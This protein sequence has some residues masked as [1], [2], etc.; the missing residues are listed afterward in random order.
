MEPEQGFE[1]PASPHLSQ[2]SELPGSAKACGLRVKQ[3]SER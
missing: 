1:A 2:T 3:C